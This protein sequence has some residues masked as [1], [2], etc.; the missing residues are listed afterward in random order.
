MS[1]PRSNVVVMEDT[2]GTRVVLAAWKDEDFW[3]LERTN[4]AGMTGHLG[5][6][7]S[8]EKLVTRHRRYLAMAVRDDTGGMFRVALAEGGQTVGS[9]GYWP[10]EWQGGTVWETGWAVLPEFQ[11]RGLAVAAAREVT[12]VSRAAGMHR[13]LHAFPSVGNAA[14]NSVCRRAGFEFAGEAAFE[15]PKGTWM[16]CHD[17]RIDLTATAG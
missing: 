5:G 8:E 4:E 14:S 15:Y 12:A 11:R 10:R 16:Q 13:Y 3:L 17:W 9:V 2:G 1:Y 6:P 7:E